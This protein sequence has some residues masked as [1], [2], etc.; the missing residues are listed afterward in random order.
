MYDWIVDNNCKPH[1]IVD[2]SVGGCEV[3]EEYVLEDKRIVLNISESATWDFYIDDHYVGFGARF[4]GEPHKIKVPIS[5]VTS[6]YEKE[7]GAGLMLGVATPHEEPEPEP[8]I[9]EKP[10]LRLV[11]NNDEN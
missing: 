9:K 2:T 6:I 5:A 4:N 3:P 10:H 1:I 7:S 8:E 11:V